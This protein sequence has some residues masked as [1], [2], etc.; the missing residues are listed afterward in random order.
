MR[1]SG[2]GWKVWRGWARKASTTC[3]VLRPN[4]R[5]ERRPEHLHWIGV[6]FGKEE[7]ERFEERVREY[8]GLGVGLEDATTLSLYRRVYVALEVLWCAREFNADVTQVAPLLSHVLEVLGLPPIFAL[9]NT[10]HSTN[11]W[12]QELA[13]GSFQEIRRSLS[14]MVGTLL[15][16]SL[17]SPSSVLDCLAG[18]R[19]KDAILAI[20]SEVHDG[21]RNNSPFTISVLPLIA[22]HVRDLARSLAVDS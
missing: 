22:R 11:K 10:L 21:M 17:N 16:R 15:Q 8:E 9:E 12:E 6:A 13:A 5:P 14:L 3:G 2:F 4:K 18:N 20:M 7:L 19:H 1:C